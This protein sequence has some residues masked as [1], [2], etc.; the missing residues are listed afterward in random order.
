[1]RTVQYSHPTQQSKLTSSEI[2]REN[3]PMGPAFMKPIS[4]MPMMDMNSMNQMNAQFMQ[5]TSKEV[6]P[7][8]QFQQSQE[9]TQQGPPGG[10]FAPGSFLGMKAPLTF[11]HQVI[12]PG[13]SFSYPYKFATKGSKVTM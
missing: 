11:S 5:K 12:T 8:T 13:A 4:G 6:P 10:P 2:A 7:P 9:S 3:N 1:M